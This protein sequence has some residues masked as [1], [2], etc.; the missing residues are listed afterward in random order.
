MSRTIRFHLDENCSHAIA[1]G[2]GR[3]GIDVTTTPQGESHF[4]RISFSLGNAL[5]SSHP[6][7]PISIHWAT[8]QPKV[9]VRRENSPGGF[10]VPVHCGL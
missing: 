9:I 3:R 10:Y 2:L 4:S 8:V 1:L 5:S 7:L 6:G